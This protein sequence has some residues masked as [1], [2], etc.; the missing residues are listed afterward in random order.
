ME[1]TLSE[2]FRCHN[3][4][5]GAEFSSIFTKPCAPSRRLVGGFVGG[6]SCGPGRIG[7]PAIPRPGTGRSETSYRHQNGTREGRGT[8]ASSSSSTVL[9]PARKP[10]GMDPLAPVIADR[11]GITSP[12]FGI[13]L[14]V[15]QGERAGILESHL[16]IEKRQRCCDDDFRR[17]G[18]GFRGQTRT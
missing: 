3:A 8:R 18:A 14:D 7:R 11:P 12:D 2:S 10:T 13:F 16:P 4:A 15:A 1:C 9:G 6:S 17:T 5:K